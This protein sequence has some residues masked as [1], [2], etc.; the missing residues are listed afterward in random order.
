[1]FQL[2]SG[3]EAAMQITSAVLLVFGFACRLLA[4]S[5]TCEAD[6]RHSI[7]HCVL[8]TAG[9]ASWLATVRTDVDSYLAV[10]VSNSGAKKEAVIDLRCCAGR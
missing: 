10:V 7:I 3:T 2:V 5:F 6:P 1:M 4:Q 9:P 8:H